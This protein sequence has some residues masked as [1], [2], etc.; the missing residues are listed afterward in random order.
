MGISHGSTLR[1]EGTRT[2]LEVRPSQLTQ[3]QLVIYSPNSPP[4]DEHKGKVGYGKAMLRRTITVSS[5]MLVSDLKE[6]ICSLQKRPLL[7]SR[8][9]SVDISGCRAEVARTRTVVGNGNI[10]IVKSAKP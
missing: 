5:N 4:V 6:L 8:Y 1:V 7:V 3:L 9:R 10:F 2:S